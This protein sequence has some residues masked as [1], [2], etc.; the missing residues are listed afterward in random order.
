MKGGKA[1]V[2][3]TLFELSAASAPDSSRLLGPQMQHVPSSPPGCGSC[4]IWHRARRW[5]RLGW[6]PP[7]DRPSTSQQPSDS[8]A[9]RR[10]ES[11]GL[12]DSLADRSVAGCH[13]A[14]SSQRPSGQSR[15]RR[16]PTREA[17]RGGRLRPCGDAA[18][19]RAPPLEWRSLREAQDLRQAAAAAWRGVVDTFE[20]SAEPRTPIGP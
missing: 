8:P 14:Q 7:A 12:S 9:D 5:L 18:G 4:P 17:A 16:G 1:G 15:A 2:S 13:G 10:A 19:A 20:L 11:P 3:W 6:D